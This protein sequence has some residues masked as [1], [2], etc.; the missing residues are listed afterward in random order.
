MEALLKSSEAS[1]L[2][3]SLADLGV[4]SLDDMALCNP[5]D[6]VA[7]LKVD[8]DLAKKLVDGAKEAQLFEK[9]KTAIQS[10][11]KA[12][13]D[14]LGVEA[15]KL[16]YKR[17]FE[18]YPDVVPMFGDADMDEQAEKLLKT[19]SLA[20]EYLKDVPALIP[21]L[22]DLGAK[23]ATDWKVQK[24]HYDA[25]GE[26]LL[27]TLET[28]LGDAWTGDV[29]E[30]WTWVYGVIGSTM[31]GAGEK[32]YFE[33]RKEIIQS[34]W[35]TVGDSLGVEATKLF[36]KRLFEEYPEVV[37]MFGDADMDKQAEKLL[38]T[39][40]LAVEYLNDMGELVPILQG[41]GEKH[42]KEWKVKREHYAPVGASL[43]W[44]L[45]TGLGEAWTE[46][47]ADA[48]T[49]VYGV[50]AD[51]MADAGDKAIAEEEKE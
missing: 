27:W 24:E 18:Q 41:L 51:T 48:W 38:K 25:V 49:W 44:T 20:V 33:K 3:D 47:T 11:W 1:H 46:D 29:A 8:E 32:A 30:A 31:S 16:F 14:S 5:G 36:Y 10:T 22:E 9:R 39:V 19:V 26:C 6:L 15:T 35:K 7:D 23:H 43:L 2:A 13:G 28:G 50:I 4:E 12:V 42:A 17:L 40:S 21:I 34:T 37:P 45:E